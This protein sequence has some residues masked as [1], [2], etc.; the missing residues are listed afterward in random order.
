MLEVRPRIREGD[1]KTRVSPV[2]RMLAAQDGEFYK[3]TD[4]AAL[5]GVAP[6]TLRRLLKREEIK[7]PTYEAQMGAIHVYLY[8]PDDINELKA[9]FSN[10][11]EKRS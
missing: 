10:T 5:I 4:A 6:I 7:A 8:T 11:A 3:L 2:D 1:G 9:Y